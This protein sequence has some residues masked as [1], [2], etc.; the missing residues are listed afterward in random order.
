MVRIYTASKL[1]E[2]YLR[3]G[4]MQRGAPVKSMNFVALNLRAKSIPS[5]SWV[6][7]SPSRSEVGRGSSPLPPRTPPSQVERFRSSARRRPSPFRS[8]PWR[9]W[10]CGT[11]IITHGQTNKHFIDISLR[12]L[13]VQATKPNKSRRHKPFIRKNT[14]R[15]QKKKRY[16]IGHCWV[17]G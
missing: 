1:E 2:Q 8:L 6:R 9:L 10:S 4:Q 12:P 7:E 17:G 13:T 5:G 14:R 11:A 16:S 3:E 15:R